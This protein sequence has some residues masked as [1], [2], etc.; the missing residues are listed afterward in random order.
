MRLFLVLFCLLIASSAF[1]T[2]YIPGNSSS[3]V[4]IWKTSVQG[5]IPGMYKSL[6]EIQCIKV[7]RLSSP[8]NWY[9]I[10]ST[11]SSPE[12]ITL[13]QAGDR[14]TYNI[15]D[16]DVE[17]II[18]Y[19][20]LQIGTTGIVYNLMYKMTK[21]Q[22]EDIRDSDKPVEMDL[23][24]GDECVTLILPKEM[25]SEIYSLLSLVERKTIKE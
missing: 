5:D 12:M 16:E 23:Y 8:I 17:L 25:K 7:D 24:N 20:E 6:F 1:S 22:L 2:I 18:L 11:G 21:E 10:I 14:L 9:F 3:N 13:W 4:Q 15:D 19:E